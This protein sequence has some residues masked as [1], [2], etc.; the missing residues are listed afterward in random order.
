MPV[1]GDIMTTRWAYEAICVEQFKNNTFEKP[2]FKYDM[3]I[4]QS[5]WYA[6]FLIPMLKVKVEECVDC[7]K[8]SGLQEIFRRKLQEN[9]LSYQ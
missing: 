6:S 5:S 8:E 7:R 1:I 2:F 9:Q 3:E 4:S